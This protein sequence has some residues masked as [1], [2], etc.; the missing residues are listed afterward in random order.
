MRLLALTCLSLLAA[1]LP[2][3]DFSRF[4]ERVPGLFFFLGV[5]PTGRDPLSA[6]ANHSPLYDVDEAAIPTGIKALSALAIDALTYGIT[7][8]GSMK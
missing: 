6:P 2:A 3:Q 1:N 8:L 7:P 5:T 4:L